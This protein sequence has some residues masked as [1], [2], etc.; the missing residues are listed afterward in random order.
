MLRT[1]RTLVAFQPS[2]RPTGCEIAQP[3]SLAISTADAATSSGGCETVL[4]RGT[5]AISAATSAP[6]TSMDR[7]MLAT[8]P[9][10]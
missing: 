8:E 3:L 7:A 2:G 10:A 6:T 1:K 5:M 9:E 4:T